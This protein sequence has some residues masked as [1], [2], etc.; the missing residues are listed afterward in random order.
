M[1]AL[2]SVVFGGVTCDIQRIHLEDHRLW[3]TA[4]S[5]HRGN[6]QVDTYAE[7]QVYAPDGTLISDVPSVSTG[8]HTQ[9]TKDGHLHAF[10]PMGL[11]VNVRTNGAGEQVTF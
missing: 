10:L 2:G 1:S 6:Y 4:K 9:T 5:R 8:D 3:L 11:Q 7:F